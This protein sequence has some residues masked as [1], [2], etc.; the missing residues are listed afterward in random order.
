ML[1]NKGKHVESM[2]YGVLGPVQSIPVAIFTLGY[3]LPMFLTRSS[4]YFRVWRTRQQAVS[5]GMKTS[6]VLQD[7]L[8]YYRE[9]WWIEAE[10]NGE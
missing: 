10:F 8:R 1:H 3:I 5:S 6:P 4:V 9:N 7:F 2:Q